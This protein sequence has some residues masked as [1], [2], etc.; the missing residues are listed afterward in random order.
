MQKEN[1]HF[2]AIPNCVGTE[3][4]QVWNGSKEPSTMQ[5]G[6]VRSGG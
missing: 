3:L 5:H 2:E 1:A 4:H 6:T